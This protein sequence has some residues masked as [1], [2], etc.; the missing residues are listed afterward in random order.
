MNTIAATNPSQTAFEE[1]RFREY[2][3]LDLNSGRAREASPGTIQWSWACRKVE[4]TALVPLEDSASAPP[5]PGDLALVRVQKAGFHKNLPT[6]ENRRLRIYPEA[7]FVGVFGNP[8]AADAY[9]AEVEGTPS[10]SDLCRR[11]GNEQRKALARTTKPKARA[12]L[13]EDD[14]ILE[15][16][17]GIVSRFTLDPHS[18]QDMLQECLLCLW[19]AEGQNPGRTVS[20]YLQRC[21]FHVQHWLM[22]GRSLDSPKRASAANRITI[23]GDDEEPALAEH[24]TNGE[25]IETVCV[26]DLIAT[27]AKG[28]KPSELFVLGGLAAGLTLRKVASESRLSYPTALKY[29]RK[30]AALALKLGLVASPPQRKS[31]KMGRRKRTGR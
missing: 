23:D 31:T 3:P 22:L 17:R 4:S 27:L 20:W 14:K 24:H 10:E 30:I 6:A 26:R 9:E 7:Q 21:R 12:S 18:R 28:L 11:H 1:T 5:L 19:L 15:S 29:R 2:N 25:V 13:L 16:V 8:S